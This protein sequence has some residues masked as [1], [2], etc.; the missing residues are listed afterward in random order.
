MSDVC[1]IRDQGVAAPL[2]DTVEC[3]I[4]D[5]VE[6]AYGALFGPFGWAGGVLTAA[7]TIYIAFFA[8]QLITGRTSLHLSTVT[9]RLVLVAIIVVLATR[10]GTYQTLVFDVMFDGAEEVAG[11]MIG[12]SPRGVLAADETVTDRLDGVLTSLAASASGQQTKGGASGGH[13]RT[14]REAM[15]A[16]SESA[17]ARTSVPSPAS[18]ATLI[19]VSLAT[20]ALGSVGVLV[21][22]KVLLGVLLAVG[23]LFLLFALFPTTRGLFEG[24]LRTV[25]SYALVPL[26]VLVLTAGVLNLVEPLAAQI[27]EGGA[28]QSPLDPSLLLIIVT[29]IFAALMLQVLWLTARLTSGWS[30]PSGQGPMGAPGSAEDAPS[31]VMPV[32][33]QSDPRI[34]TLIAS[35]DH[36]G[37]TASPAGPAQAQRTDM[38]GLLTAAPSRDQ[39]RPSPS[40]RPLGAKG[41][42]GSSRLVSAGGRKP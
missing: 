5:Y 25:V 12:A 15:A 13:P 41:V 30:L 32:Q 14:V 27:A 20:L 37:F 28:G 24:W 7:L 3:Q 31:T 4:A 23:P 19:W 34:A 35:I 18:N 29:L 21:I 8:F 39:A 33:P 2:L 40:R 9:V 42:R 22:S 6:G 38:T 26:F 36:P 1:H 16:A 11:L 10:W 17:P